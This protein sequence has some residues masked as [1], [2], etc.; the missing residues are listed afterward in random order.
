MKNRSRDPVIMTEKELA[1]LYDVISKLNTKEDLIGAM[2]S[3]TSVRK[4]LSEKEMIALAAKLRF[5]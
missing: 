2:M 5:L 4:F 1:Y 3:R